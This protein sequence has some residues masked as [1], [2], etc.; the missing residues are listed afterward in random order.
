M[1]TSHQLLK[2]FGD[3]YVEERC[4]HSCSV[5]RT[6]HT[7]NPRECFQNVGRDTIEHSVDG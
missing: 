6:H 7:G 3:L 2:F 4:W 5:K 1:K